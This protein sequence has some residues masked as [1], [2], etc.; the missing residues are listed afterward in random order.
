MSVRKRRFGSARLRSFLQ[1]NAAAGLGI[2]AF[3]AV[4][5]AWPIVSSDLWWHLAAGRDIV[6]GLAVPVV[7][8]FSHTALGAPWIDF[9]WLFQV[10]LFFLHEA[11]GMH[12]L[13]WF[14]GA[15]GAAAVLI[16]YLCA[17]EAGAS[18]GPALLGAVCAL[19]LV[20]TRGFVRPELA[21]LVLAP[22]TVYLVVRARRRKSRDPLYFLPAIVAL[23][24]NLHAGFPVGLGFLLLA[25]LG[26][27]WQSP[28]PKKRESVRL[29]TAGGGGTSS[30]CP[31][32]G[33]AELLACF[34]ACL[35]A[36]WI[37]PYGP[38]LY[39]IIWEHLIG[40]EASGIAEWRALRLG[41]Y[42]VYW[43]LLTAAFA[44]LMRDLLKRRP[45]AR[46]WAPAIVLFGLWSSRQ[47]RSPVYFAFV[48]VPYLFA[49]LSHER[50]RSWELARRAAPFAALALALWC[51]HP[52]LRRNFGESVRRHYFPIKAA[53]FLERRGIEGTIYNDC[54][55]GGY[56]SW[57]FGRER[58]TFCDSRYLFHGEIRAQRLGQPAGVFHNKLKRFGVDYA[59][60]RHAAPRTSDDEGNPLPV[61]R[62][63][64]K[65]LFPANDW[66]LVYWDD[67]ALIFLRRLPRFRPL[68]RRLEFVRLDPDDA[69]YLL[70]LAAGDPGVRKSLLREL[71]RHE[72][73]VGFTVIGDWLRRRLARLGPGPHN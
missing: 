58:P 41:E 3:S 53:D 56:L 19:V 42:P 14:K 7:D 29:S 13:V 9:E 35:A 32:V 38:R 49:R 61:P 72:K 63:P 55:F 5:L 10:W 51:A 67:T 48:A 73:R 37:N 45:E 40:A 12:L 70:E 17:R 33:A 23:W 16:V 26:A 11:G 44:V 71:V 28:R 30:G 47:V 57:R 31:S 60:V 18:R 50:G 66:A 43:A 1:G 34:A 15:L 22:A 8:S 64:W 2:W 20:R 46:F 69:A 4:V 54:G 65:T 25:A 62:S 68:I 36:S 24:A 39:G 52:V 27:W 6:G 21:S 59:L